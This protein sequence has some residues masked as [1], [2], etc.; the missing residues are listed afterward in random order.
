MD[1]VAT[2]YGYCNA[3]L[4]LQMMAYSERKRSKQ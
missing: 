2:M 1:A 3:P 4:E